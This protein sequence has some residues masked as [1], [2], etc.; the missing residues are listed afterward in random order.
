MRQLGST[1]LKRLHREWR[2]RPSPRLALL[3]DNVATPFNVG[4]ILR[5]AAA[6]RID[7]LWMAGTTASP[8]LERTRKTAL[9][10]ERFLSW[11]EVDTGEGGVSAA[12][13]DGYRVVG[14]ELA[15]EAVPLHDAD[16][17]GDVC[18]AVGHE[19]RGLNASC[20]AACDEVAFIPQLG[21]IGSLNVAVATAVAI[22]EARR[23]TWAGSPPND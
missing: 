3:L 7:H 20:L 18:L 10:S 12:R 17:S 2:H 16:L 22:Y 21:R 9:G 23:R 19:D 8:T 11:T 4:S 1:D 15:D 5:T 14:I 13:R 6:E